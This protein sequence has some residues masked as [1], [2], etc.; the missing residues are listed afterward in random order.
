[1][2]DHNTL[3]LEISEYLDPNS[4]NTCKL[5]RAMRGDTILYERDY[6]SDHP[7]VGEMYADYIEFKNKNIIK[8]YTL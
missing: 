7:D 1:M 5:V 3:V 2:V 6:G 4:K 8:R